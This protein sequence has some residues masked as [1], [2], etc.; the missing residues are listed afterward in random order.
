MEGVVTYV[1]CVCNRERGLENPVLWL[2]S[3][4]THRKI[5]WA[6]EAARAVPSSLRCVGTEIHASIG[7]CPLERALWRP[8]WRGRTHRGAG[9]EHFRLCIC[10]CTVFCIVR[11][12]P[13]IYRSYG[14]YVMYVYIVLMLRTANTAFEA[15]QREIPVTIWVLIH[16]QICFW[17]LAVWESCSAKFTQY[18]KASVSKVH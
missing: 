10:P 5:L 15:I 7:L 12:E 13:C 17:L 2:Q 4:R 3:H 18:F 11:A 8:A 14:V 9:L 6:Q 1:K 16:C